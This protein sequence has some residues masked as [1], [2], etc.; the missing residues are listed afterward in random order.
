MKKAIQLDA[1]IIKMNKII[2][3]DAYYIDFN[4]QITCTFSII[5]VLIY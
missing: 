4:P 2:Y 3:C 1:K 5:H